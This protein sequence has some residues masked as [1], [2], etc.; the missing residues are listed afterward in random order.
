V[1]TGSGG[2]SGLMRSSLRRI[3]GIFDALFITKRLSICTRLSKPGGRWTL[4]T[5]PVLIESQRAKAAPRF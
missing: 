3:T 5:D 1:L 2:G 4:A